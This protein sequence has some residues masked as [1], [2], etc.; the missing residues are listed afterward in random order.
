MHFCGAEFKSLGH[1]T[2]WCKE[3]LKDAENSNTKS[4]K[5]CSTS[6]NT[7]SLAIDDS[8]NASNFSEIKCCCGKHCNGLLGLKMHQRSCR[9]FKSMTSETFEDL[10]QRNFTI[11]GQDLD[12]VDWD[13]LPYI[14]L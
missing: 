13:S 12:S 9:V 8:T 2:W 3:K 7:L 5:L 11:T 6:R 4:S 1:H 10:Q 14:K